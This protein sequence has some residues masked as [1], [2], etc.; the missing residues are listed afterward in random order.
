MLLDFLVRKHGVQLE[1]VWGKTLGQ[2]IRDHCPPP[3]L[4]EQTL[5][6][7]RLL[8]D[9]R[10]SL[11]PGAALRDKDPDPARSDALLAL[12]FLERLIEELP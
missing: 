7:A 12:A 5:L 4:A 1:D 11:H 3:V 8:K 2:L 6:T 9:F 10:N